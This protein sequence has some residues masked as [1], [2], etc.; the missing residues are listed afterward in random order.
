MMYQDYLIAVLWCVVA[1]FRYT[2]V[3]RENQL[4]F[5]DSR[6]S[7]QWRDFA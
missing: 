6:E 3:W 1:H 2:A 7:G 5:S 4:G